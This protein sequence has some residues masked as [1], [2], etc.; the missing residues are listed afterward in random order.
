MID[1]QPVYRILL[2]FDSK[3]IKPHIKQAEKYVKEFCEF[4]RAEEILNA[5]ITGFSVSLY[6]SFSYKWLRVLIEEL[7]HLVASIKKVRVYLDGR[8]RPSCKL[9]KK[10][11]T[12]K[13]RA[14]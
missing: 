12:K 3:E 10:N 13:G 9:A 14:S 1:F 2:E 5:L 4:Y 11:S 6:E 7:K 8:K